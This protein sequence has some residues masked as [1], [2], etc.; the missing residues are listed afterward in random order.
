M[1]GMSM[2]H[3]S[4]S[5]GLAAYAGMWMGMMVP[6]MVPSLI[7]VL[8]SYRRA[9]RG[10]NGMRLHGLTVMVS[11]GYF[12]V[13]A[14]LGVVAFVA[15]T[16]FVAAT[17]RWGVGPWRAPIASGAVFLAAGLVQLSPWKSR[18]LAR[19]RDRSGCGVPLAPHAVDAWRHGRRL[20]VECAL[21][22]SGLMMALLAAGMMNLVATVLV[23]LAITAERLAP[24]PQWVGRLAGLTIVI[25]G[26][27]TVARI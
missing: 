15:S 25:I 22:C 23:A 3:E 10:T 6:M 19:C 14:V 11:G 17:L 16:G 18:Q 13:W 21:C 12:A 20:G 5:G 24:A 9:V 2:G 27:L 4:W 7:P 26:V 8:A 1:S